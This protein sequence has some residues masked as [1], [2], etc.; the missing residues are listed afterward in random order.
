MRSWF[1]HDGQYLN[2]G[3]FPTHRCEVARISTHLTSYFYMW[4]RVLIKINV[5]WPLIIAELDV[6]NITYTMSLKNLAGEASFSLFYKEDN[7]QLYKARTLHSW[8]WQ[9]PD[10]FKLIWL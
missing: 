10:G 8:S 1:I 5:Y 2:Q 3:L 4:P 9:K 7:W 6:E